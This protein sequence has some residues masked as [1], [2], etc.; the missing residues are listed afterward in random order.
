MRGRFVWLPLVASCAWAC[1]CKPSSPAPNQAPPPPA[2]AAT[3]PPAA[4][5]PSP[6][7]E[8]EP[9][10]ERESGEAQMDE[11]ARE[12]KQRPTGTPTAEAVLDA[13]DAQGIKIERRRQVLARAVQASF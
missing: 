5:A 12:A 2:K 13:L 4:A 7:P 3:P 11:L 10:V 8:R 9:T 6:V 1:A